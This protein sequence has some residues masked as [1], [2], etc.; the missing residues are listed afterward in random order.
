MR[1]VKLTEFHDLAPV[2]LHCEQELNGATVSHK[3]RRIALFP[4]TGRDQDGGDPVLKL[5]L[6]V[7]RERV[8]ERV[9]T[10]N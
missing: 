6:P 1:T 2:G 3:L 4:E 9:Y 5:S 8:A 7:E 10:L